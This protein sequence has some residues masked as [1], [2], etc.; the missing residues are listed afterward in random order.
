MYNGKRVAMFRKY[1]KDKTVSV[2]YKEIPKDDIVLSVSAT[3]L[4]YRFWFRKEGE[5]A[6]LLGTAPTKD[7]STEIIAGFIGVYIGMYASGNGS[8]NT[9]PAD[10]D[11]FNYEENY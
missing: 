5:S 4:K 8:A 2:D 7:I 9:Y 10:F 1:L 3:D 11:W 6:V